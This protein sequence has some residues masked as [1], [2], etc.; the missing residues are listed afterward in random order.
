VIREERVMT[1]SKL[2]LL[3]LFGVFLGW[4][5]LDW[6]V[7][8]MKTLEELRT[9]AFKSLTCLYIAAPA[10]AADDVNRKVKAYIDALEEIALKD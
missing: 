7:Q 2:I 9:E 4:V 1:F 10:Y 8:Y 6:K 5:I 3:F